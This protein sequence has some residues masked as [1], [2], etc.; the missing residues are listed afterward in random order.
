MSKVKVIKKKSSGTART[1]AQNNYS[2]TS[3]A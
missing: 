2:R 3:M 1:R